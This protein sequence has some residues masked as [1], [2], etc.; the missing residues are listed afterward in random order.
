MDKAA[1]LLDENL[2]KAFHTFVMKAMFVCKQEQDIQP[3]V[4]FLSSRTNELNESDWNKLI[5]MMRFLWFVQD[6]A[7]IVAADG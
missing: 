3:A 6:H 5:R 1:T 4:T 7:M 2:K